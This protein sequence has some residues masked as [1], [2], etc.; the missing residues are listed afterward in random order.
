MTPEPEQV[1]VDNTK[2]KEPVERVI[3]PVEE[4]IPQAMSASRKLTNPINQKVEIVPEMLGLLCQNKYGCLEEVIYPIGWSEDGKFAYLIEGAY[5]AVNNYSLQ[6]FIQD[7][8]TDKIIAEKLWK[9]SDQPGWSESKDYDFGM[10]WKSQSSVFSK[11]LE[12]NQIRSGDGIRFYPLPYQFDGQRYQF[13][14]GDKM[15][16]SD[17]TGDEV[18][19]EHELLA[20]APGLGQKSLG[21]QTFGKYDMVQ[22]T[23]ALGLFKSPFEDRVAVLDG[24]EYRGYEGPPN[25]LRFKLM[26]CKLKDGF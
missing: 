1:V 11:L 24:A 18:V 9:A 16:P 20:I 21:K 22:Q 8:K 5:E 15:V 3:T 26:G 7:M 10:A 4:A 25:V 13:K 12:E 19:G 6:L 17:Y 14:N 2:T 23:H